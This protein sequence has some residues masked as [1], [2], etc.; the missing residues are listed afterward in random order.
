M[1]KNSSKTGQETLSFEEALKRLEKIVSD[2]EG[3]D[4]P[5][6]KTIDLYEEGMNLSKYC[7]NTLDKSE[8]KL[9]KLTKNLDGSF[10]LKSIDD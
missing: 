3:G 8:A 6:D 1:A 5:L 9:K 4:T 7:L 2:I 10:E